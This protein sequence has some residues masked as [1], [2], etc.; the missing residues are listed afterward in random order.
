MKFIKTIK[1]KNKI[2][3]KFKFST[4]SKSLVSYN[5]NDNKKIGIITINNSLKRNAYSLEL[6]LQL[7]SH[8]LDI[9]NRFKNSNGLESSIIILSS[10]GEFFSSGHDLKELSTKSKNEQLDIF[11]LAGEIC[12]LINKSP[13]IFISEIQGLAAAAGC[14]LAMTCDIAIATNK[15]TFSTPGIKVGLFCTTPSVALYKTVKNTKR[16]MDMLLTGDIINANTALEWGMLTKII[17]VNTAKDFTEEKHM[18]RMATLEY[19]NKVGKFSSETYSFGKKAFYKQIEK[20]NISDSYVYAAEKMRE[21][22]NFEDC[23]EGVKAFIEKRQ[24]KYKY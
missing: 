12:V 3:S 6:L 17:S 5:L 7:K 22:F 1:A 8:I 4:D 21:N 14:Q 15:A 11:N 18:L 19:A 23:K 24:A 9:N 20:E 10:E 16:V 2:L 13:S